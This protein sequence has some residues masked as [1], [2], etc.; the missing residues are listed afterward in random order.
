LFSFVILLCRKG[1][2]GPELCYQA[3]VTQTGGT[4]VGLAHREK[5]KIGGLDR[6]RYDTQISN[7]IYFTAT[8]PTKKINSMN[9]NGGS[10]QEHT[11]LQK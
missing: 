11:D 9:T 6:L 4:E 2:T 8:E 3:H 7:L 5:G 10:C 1:L